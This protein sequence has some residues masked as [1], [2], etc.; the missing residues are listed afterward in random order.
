MAVKIVKNNTV[1]AIIIVD[2]GNV[3]I[4]ASGQYLIPPEDYLIWAESDDIITEVGS[5]DVTVNDGNVD[6]SIARGTSYLQFG[7]Q[8]FLVKTPKNETLS[9]PLAATEVSH[10]FPA[11]TKRFR[12]ANRDS[13]ILQLAYT[14]T[15]SGTNY[16]TI[17][18][19]SE[20]SE[21]FILG[22]TTTIYLQSPDANQ[23]VELISWI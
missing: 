19:G 18:C 14:A 22:G 11:G 23:T 7:T 21:D 17:Y 2:V 12:I 20:Y 3:T 4:P 13:G 5:G 6:L 10:S 9:I 16:K 15:E 8:Q 1:S